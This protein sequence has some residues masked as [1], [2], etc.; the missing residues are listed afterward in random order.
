MNKHKV[1]TETL[2]RTEAYYVYGIG[3]WDAL[4]EHTHKPQQA[5]L[6]AV[7]ACAKSDTPM[8]RQRVVKTANAFVEAWREASNK[9][10]RLQAG[11]D[12]QEFR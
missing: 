1:I 3:Y 8:N 6:D 7:D 11:K 12:V 10:K 9:Y 5:F 4:W 2:K